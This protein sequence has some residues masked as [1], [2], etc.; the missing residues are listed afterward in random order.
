[1]CLGAPVARETL[2]GV[3]DAAQD[4]PAFTR[5]TVD[6]VVPLLSTVNRGDQAVFVSAAPAA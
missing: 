1:V 6:R 4:V 3:L 2:A 5:C